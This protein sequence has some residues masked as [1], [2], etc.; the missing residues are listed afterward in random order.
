MGRKIRSILLLV[1]L[2]VLIYYQQ[3]PLSYAQ[4]I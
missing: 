1:L 2:M 3:S 4:N